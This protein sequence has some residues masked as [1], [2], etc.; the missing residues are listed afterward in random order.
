MKRCLLIAISI[1]F[2]SNTLWAGKHS[3]SG[4]VVD[5][6]TGETIIG[7][8]IVVKSTTRGAATDGNG[9]FVIPGLQPGNYTLNFMH[10]AYEKKSLAVQLI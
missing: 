7:A 3:I 6:K 5:G 1:L 10:I 2:V 8:N 9:Y 4:Y